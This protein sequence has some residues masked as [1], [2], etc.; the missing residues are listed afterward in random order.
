MGF[1]YARLTVI[2]AAL[3]R[4]YPPHTP[5]DDQTPQPNEWEVTPQ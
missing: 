3:N 2:A 5:P 4:E 1:A